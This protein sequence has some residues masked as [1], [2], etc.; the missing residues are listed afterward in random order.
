MG[1]PIEIKTLFHNGTVHI[2]LKK[3]AKM[4][5]ILQNMDTRPTPNEFEFHTSWVKKDK[6]FIYNI[7]YCT[8]TE[9]STSQY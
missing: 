3:N 4:Y 2:H 7:M 1:K 6:F 8:W 9:G 5:I